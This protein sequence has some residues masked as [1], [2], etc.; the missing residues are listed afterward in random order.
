MQ[1]WELKRKV[2][3][4]YYF[5][6]NKRVNNIIYIAILKDGTE[7]QVKKEQVDMFLT[8][9]KNEIKLQNWINKNMSLRINLTRSSLVKG[10]FK[11][12]KNLKEFYEL[13]ER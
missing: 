13:K 6:E 5:T 11:D 1:N 4:Y 9:A 10:L 3:T 12:V 7:Y 2:K 8:Y